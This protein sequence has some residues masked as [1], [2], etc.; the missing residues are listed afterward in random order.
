VAS[1]WSGVEGIKL[2]SEAVRDFRAWST[3]FLK[4]LT[5]TKD[6]DII[7]YVIWQ[8]KE[9]AKSRWRRNEKVKIVLKGLGSMDPMKKQS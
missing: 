8:E 5:Y 7:R 2:R 1:C 6:S 3:S 9:R 4:R